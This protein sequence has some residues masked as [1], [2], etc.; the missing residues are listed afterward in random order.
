VIASFFVRAIAEILHLGINIYIFII[1]A[2]AIISW[3]G[4]IPPNRFIF[5]LRKVTDPV[6]RF[7]HRHLPFTIIGGIDISPIFI[8]L[9]LYLADYLVVGALMDYS[10]Y[11]RLG[12]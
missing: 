3:A 7:V 1:L 11:L 2:R 10:R 6:F 9:A 12:Y 8:V 4:T 5:L